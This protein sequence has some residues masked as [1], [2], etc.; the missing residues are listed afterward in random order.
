MN[1][2]AA[3]DDIRIIFIFFRVFL[4]S[5]DVTNRMKPRIQ[6]QVGHF[7]PE[8]PSDIV[9][10]GD[11]RYHIFIRGTFADDFMGDAAYMFVGFKLLR[12]SDLQPVDAQLFCGHQSFGKFGSE[13]V[14]ESFF[15]S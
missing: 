6:S 13:G 7:L 15:H 4:S 8:P 11:V 12:T 14:F 9:N 2:I 3:A 5:L 1:Q 10:R